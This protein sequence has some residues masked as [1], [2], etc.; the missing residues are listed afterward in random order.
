MKK[1]IKLKKKPRFTK[2]I[3]FL[4]VPNRL[5]YLTVSLTDYGDLISSASVNS[6]LVELS[7]FCMNL[8]FSFNNKSIEICKS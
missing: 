2:K 7:H 1:I 6:I 4:Q 8:S 5:N 3:N